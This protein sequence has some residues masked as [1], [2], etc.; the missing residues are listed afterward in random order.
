MADAPEEETL[1]HPFA[2]Y[3]RSSAL[4]AA[5]VTGTPAMAA[6]V[7]EGYD[8]ALDAKRGRTWM[9]FDSCGK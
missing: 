3:L 1:E 9:R 8:Q 4:V 6:G 2:K 5:I 7:A